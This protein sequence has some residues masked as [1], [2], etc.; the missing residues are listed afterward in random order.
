[1]L[2]VNLILTLYFQVKK[3]KNQGEHKTVIKNINKLNYVYN[4]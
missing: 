2:S 1:M 3:E 4:C